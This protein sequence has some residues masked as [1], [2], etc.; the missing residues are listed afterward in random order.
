MRVRKTCAF[1]LWA[2]NSPLI[3][4]NFPIEVLKQVGDWFERIVGTWFRVSKQ[5][6][7][8]FK[9]GLVGGVEEE[10]FPEGGKGSV[11]NGSYGV[12]FDVVGGK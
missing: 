6:Q 3:D 12:G 5:V 7:E 11:G 2:V 9:C 1:P 10:M 8:E 4:V